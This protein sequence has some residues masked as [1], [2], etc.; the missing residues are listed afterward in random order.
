[1]SELVSIIIPTYNRAHL[2]GDTLDSIINQTYSKWECIIIDDGREDETRSLVQNYIGRDSRFKYFARPGSLKSGTSS[3]RNYGFKKSQGT[4]INWFDDD[5]IML[6]EFLETKV[7]QF[8]P[9][10]DSVVCKLTHYDFQKNVA[11]GETKIK[12]NNLLKDYLVGKVIFFVSGPLWKR[13]FLLKQ[14]EMFDEDISNLDDWDFNLRMLYA[15][16][17]FAFINKALVLYRVHNESLSFKIKKLNFEEIKSEMKAR[18]K[19]LR[20]LLFKKNINLKDFKSFTINRNRVFLREALVLK[21]DARFFL[22][23]NLML[24][25]LVSFNFIAILKITGGFL[26]YNLTGKGYWFLK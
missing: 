15:S 14:K 22:Y 10:I 12:S 24:W 11:L 1:M 8:E 21:S 19:H 9:G 26:S 7:A 23:K 6:P 3:C 13:E 2:I 4:L 16:P 18:N 5:D 25:Y 17:N 20:I